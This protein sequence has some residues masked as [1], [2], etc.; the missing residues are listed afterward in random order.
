[1]PE[2]LVLTGDLDNADGSEATQL[3]SAT[4]NGNNVQRISS[5]TFKARG[6]QPFS[7]HCFH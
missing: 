7:E 2:L 5:N 4:V 6:G 3:Y 1:M